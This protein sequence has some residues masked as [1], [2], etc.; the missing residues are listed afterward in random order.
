MMIES[1][2][3]ILLLILLGFILLL[4]ELFVIPGFGLTGISGLVALTLACYLA[5]TKYESPW[6]GTVALLGT[7]ALLTVFIKFFPRT[8]AWKRLRLN[9]REESKEGF[10]ASSTQL[11]ELVGKTGIALTMLRPAGTAKIEG[12]R[13]DVL[14]EGI[15]LPKDTEVKVVMVKG[16]RVVVRKI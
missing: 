2:S 15:F 13:I 3:A 4:I 8:K 12:K 10:A 14:T 6:P 9:A 11:E 16:N 1:W 7:L 5:F